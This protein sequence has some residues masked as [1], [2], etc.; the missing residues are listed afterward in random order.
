MLYFSKLILY[1]HLL[2][3]K[4][5][6]NLMLVYNSLTYL[7]VNLDHKSGFLRKYS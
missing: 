5:I 2:K 1:K 7:F 3:K 4:K 6:N